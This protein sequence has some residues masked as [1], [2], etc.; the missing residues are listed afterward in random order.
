MD[1]QGTTAA[2]ILVFAH[3][4]DPFAETLKGTANEDTVRIWQP[5]DLVEIGWS[6]TFDPHP[7]VRL[8]DRRRAQ[9]WESGEM[10]G[11]W[12]QALPPLA[13]ID[14]LDERDRQYVI[15]EIRSSLAA[16]WHAAACPIIGQPASEPVNAALGPGP[17]ARIA[18]HRLGL[19]T[20]STHL[21][22]RRI[23][24]LQAAGKAVRLTALDTNAS[25]WLESAIDPEDGAK[26]EDEVA[27]AVDD[28]IVRVVA[29]LGEDLRIFVAQPDGSIHRAGPTSDDN[30]LADYIRAATHLDLALAFCCRQR[31]AWRIV[32]LSTQLPWWLASIDD[33]ACWFASWLAERC[34]PS[35]QM[36]M[37]EHRP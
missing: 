29:I 32:R 33:T 23:H 16:V 28:R 30:D 26:Q 8:T 15:A 31:G 18:M 7:E 10:A 5:A 34:R 25:H 36:A 3:P 11:I 13:R 12:F 22:I 14:G 35:R 2:P 6:V 1:P 20:V 37:G 27:I 19:P 21:G 4:D 9:T 17:E 24:A